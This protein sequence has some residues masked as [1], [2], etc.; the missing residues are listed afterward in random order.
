MLENRTQT[1]RYPIAHC[2]LWYRWLGRYCHPEKSPNRTCCNF[3]GRINVTMY[4]LGNKDLSAKIALMK[5][6]ALGKVRTSS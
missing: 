4:Y 5:V 1:V 2:L 6:S 3:T